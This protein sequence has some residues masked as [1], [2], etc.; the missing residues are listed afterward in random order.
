MFDA[1]LHCIIYPYGQNGCAGNGDRPGN[2]YG[3]GLM[4]RA[5]SV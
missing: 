1:A 5:I 2:A 4:T 3:D